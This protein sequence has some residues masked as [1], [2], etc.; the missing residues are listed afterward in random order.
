M[1]KISKSQQKDL[2]GRLFDAKTFS[3]L[4]TKSGFWQIQI[5]EKARHTT[6]FTIPFE[7]YEWN[8]RSSELKNTSSEFQHVLNNDSEFSKFSIDD[9]LAYSKFLDQYFKHLKIFFNLFKRN[10][11][12]ISTIRKKLFQTKIW[13]LGHNILNGTIKPIQ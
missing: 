4:D 5:A 8:A 2:L 13:F 9:A 7:H 1:D 10:D 6:A 12:A 3:K 11:S